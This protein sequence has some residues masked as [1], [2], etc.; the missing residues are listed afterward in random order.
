MRYAFIDSGFGLLKT[1]YNLNI[2]P[3]VASCYFMTAGV[4]P[5]GN[6]TDK[7]IS[8]IVKKLIA[9][10][11]M[12]DIDRTFI[13][14]NTLSSEFVNYRDVKN[15]L[16]YNLKLITDKTVFISTFSTYKKLDNINKKY[17]QN[18]ARHIEEINIE[19]IIDD[20]DYLDI[21]KDRTVLG[22]THYP[23]V[24]R[25]FETRFPQSEFVDGMDEML[26]MISR[27]KEKDFYADE[28]ASEI[29]K[30]FFPRIVLKEINNS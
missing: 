25:I 11:R 19:R 7:E 5:I 27:G 18:L 3:P 16:S 6:K 17:S 26:S 15:I 4:F 24:K 14:C 13:C 29:I 30:T 22:C 21:Y 2:N 12:L 10:L 20:I 9:R 8:R 1:I 28:R 23:L